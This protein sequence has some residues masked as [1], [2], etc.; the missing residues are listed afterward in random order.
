M[1]VTN[2]IEN[3]RL[4]SCL[5]TSIKYVI[6]WISEA[7]LQAMDGSSISCNVSIH[8]S[9]KLCPQTNSVVFATTA[10]VGL[11]KGFGV[12]VTI[13]GEGVITVSENIFLRY[14][15]SKLITPVY[16]LGSL[17]IGHTPN[18]PLSFI[19]YLGCTA[20]GDFYNIYLYQGDS[21]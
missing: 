2:I 8:L 4:I 13:T 21:M 7:Y 6:S 16:S 9:I 1:T 12:D 14:M 19:Y 10:V 15:I 17:W 3:S 20:G 5:H 11:V 18:F